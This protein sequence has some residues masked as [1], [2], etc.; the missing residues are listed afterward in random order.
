VYLK[1]EFREKETAAR[2]ILELKANGFGPD[3]LDVFSN[4]PVEFADGVLDRPSRMSLVVVASALTCCV[5][6]I[7]FVRYTQYNYPLVT[8]GMPLFSFWSTGVVFYELTMLGAIL[9]SFAWFL[10]ESG[11]VR[12]RNPAPVPDVEPGVICLRVRCSDEQAQLASGQLEQ[13]GAI[14]VEKL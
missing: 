13:A 6:T 3:A 14:G 11:L 9:S 4:E 2:A 10:W 7:L 8:G 12:R 1:A 5:L